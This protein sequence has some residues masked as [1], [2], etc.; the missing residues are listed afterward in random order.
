MP[1][2]RTYIELDQYPIE[3]DPMQTVMGTEIEI[4]ENGHERLVRTFE[5]A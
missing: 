3:I 4:L 5:V 2:T 1:V